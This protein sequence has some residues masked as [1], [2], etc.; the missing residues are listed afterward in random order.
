M[1]WHISL[2][3]A[4]LNHPSYY[5]KSSSSFLLHN[6]S[7]HLYLVYVSA[8]LLL[9][10]NFLEIGGVKN[11]GTSCNLLRLVAQTEIVLLIA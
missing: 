2:A 11:S 7:F 1:T 6:L 3:G 9:C 4:S 5:G 10:T 8:D